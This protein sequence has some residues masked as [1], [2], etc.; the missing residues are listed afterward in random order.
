MDEQTATTGD[1]YDYPPDDSDE[2]WHQADDHWGWGI[3]CPDCNRKAPIRNE[4]PMLSISTLKRQNLEG[5]TSREEE[6]DMLGDRWDDP[7]V[8]RAR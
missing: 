7:K 8:G 6:R 4:G 5:R 2:T 1:D 3:E